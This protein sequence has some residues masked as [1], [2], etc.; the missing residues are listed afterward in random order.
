V[1]RKAS[2][3]NES[4][5][6]CSSYQD[7]LILDITAINHLDHVASV[8]EELSFETKLFAPVL[9]VARPSRPYGA[10][11]EILFLSLADACIS[12]LS[13]HTLGLLQGLAA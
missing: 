4:T 3:Q 10:G 9:F 13:D 11:L 5:P 6:R 7:K 1:H 12:G 2:I 8:V